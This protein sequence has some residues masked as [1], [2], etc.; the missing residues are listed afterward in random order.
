MKVLYMIFHPCMT[1]ISSSVQS[2][3]RLEGAKSA[4]NAVNS[5]S[6][7]EELMDACKGFE[8]YF[9]RKIH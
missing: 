7:D 2:T 1:A 4:L 8:T 6:T 3:Y 9:V 5:D